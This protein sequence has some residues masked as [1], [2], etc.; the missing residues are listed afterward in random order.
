MTLIGTIQ[1]LSKG[2]AVDW[3]FKHQIGRLS[4]TRPFKFRDISKGIEDALKMSPEA[5]SFTVEGKS[6]SREEAEDLLRYMGVIRYKETMSRG[7]MY[8]GLADIPDR[9]PNTDSWGG[10]YGGNY[11]S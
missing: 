10:S 9:R 3:T 4:V 2:E 1:G 7:N 5:K 8:H 6:L 11:G